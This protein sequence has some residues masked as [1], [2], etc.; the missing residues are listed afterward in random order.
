M[1]TVLLAASLIAKIAD[2]IQQILFLL[3]CHFFS[4]S[5]IV[6]LLLSKGVKL[7]LKYRNIKIS[8]YWPA[9]IKSSIQS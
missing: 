3:L 8:K 2:R 6:N 5:D 4:I 9:N 1:P 7:M